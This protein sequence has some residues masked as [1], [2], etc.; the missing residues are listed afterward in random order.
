MSSQFFITQLNGSKFLQDFMWFG[1][2]FQIFGPKDLILILPKLTWLTL[3]TS[4]L[5]L[6]WLQTVLLALVTLN[7][8][9]S[10]VKDGFIEFILL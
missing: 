9:S 7:L 5:G 2:E 3:E 1:G 4:R 6:Y 10:F 8:K